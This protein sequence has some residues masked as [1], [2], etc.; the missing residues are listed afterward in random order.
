[1]TPSQ[2]LLAIAIGLYL[3]E[4][5]IWPIA[6]AT[7]LVSYSLATWN[8]HR[9]RI[10]L[11]NGRRSVFLLSPLPPLGAHFVLSRFPVAL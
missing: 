6:N 2:Q 1:M 5:L 9:P 10:Q 7:L 8:I 3:L 4:C 11:L